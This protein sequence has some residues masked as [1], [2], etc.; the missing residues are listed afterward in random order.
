MG[1]GMRRLRRVVSAPLAAITLAS[2]IALPFLD[3][4]DLPSTAAVESRH[5]PDRCPTHHDHTVCTQVGA[6]HLAP[7]GGAG[8]RADGVVYRVAAPCE[9]P[10]AIS[11]HSPACARARAPPHA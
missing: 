9:A 2:G 6:N 3:S 10:V 11:S 4:T 7:S 5:D 1:P 8:P